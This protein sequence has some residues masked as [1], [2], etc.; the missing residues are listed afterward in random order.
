MTS[1]SDQTVRAASDISGLNPVSS[2]KGPPK[3]RRSAGSKQRRK[4]KAPDAEEKLSVP[5]GEQED[6]P[7]S[8]AD[9]EDIHEVD[10][11]A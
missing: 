2:R 5:G 7:Q 1:E 10:Y 8:A 9:E 4:R 6:M 11:L 3:R